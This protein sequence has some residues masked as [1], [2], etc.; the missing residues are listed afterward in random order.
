MLGL[1]IGAHFGLRKS[2]PKYHDHRTPEWNSYFVFM[3]SSRGIECNLMFNES[4]LRGPH[5]V[6]M[7]PWCVAS[8]GNK[9]NHGRACRT[10]LLRLLH[11]HPDG[12]SVGRVHPAHIPPDRIFVQSITFGSEIRLTFSVM[13][14][15]ADIKIEIEFIVQLIEQ[16]LRCSPKLAHSIPLIATDKSSQSFTTSKLANTVKVENLYHPCIC[17]NI[18]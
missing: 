7:P 15:C 17:S 12:S 13:R 5:H 4:N 6:V 14:K 8:V 16:C 2:R 10:R 18:W 3:H 11:P 9:A 1:H